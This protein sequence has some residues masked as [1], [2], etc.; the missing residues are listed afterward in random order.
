MNWSSYIGQTR[1]VSRI[2]DSIAL[3]GRGR[4]FP[5]VLLYGPR[6]TGKTT[7]ARLTAQDLGAR[8]IRELNLGSCDNR[9]WNNYWR[10]FY[11]GQHVAF[12]DEL[13]FASKAIQ[14]KLMDAV[15]NGVHEMKAGGMVVI[16]AT[17]EQKNIMPALWNRFE[18]GYIAMLEKPS[19][20]EL[21]R[22]AK[23]MAEQRKIRPG[24]DQ[25]VSVIKASGGN[26]RLLD[27]L[28]D[29]MK[30][31]VDLGRKIDTERVLSSRGLNNEGYDSLQVRC[32]ELLGEQMNSQSYGYDPM[33]KESIAWALG[34]EKGDIEYVLGRLRVDKLVEVVTGAGVI[35]S[36]K[37]GMYLAGLF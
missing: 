17:M 30:Q 27:G 35:L 4:S 28:I 13:S 1:S 16:A 31:D 12:L 15:L 34:I 11:P 32:L 37:G 21:L 20:A 9:Q 5:L 10:A 18:A 33:T 23:G 14:K 22:I 25:L 36:R 6:G 24:A 8:S 26:L 19:N 3:T 7:L 2:Q 29:G